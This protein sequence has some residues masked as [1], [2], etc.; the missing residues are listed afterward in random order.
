MIRLPLLAIGTLVL[1]IG[2]IPDP[3]WSLEEEP[4]A[5][6]AEQEPWM[7]LYEQL[8]DRLKDLE[9]RIELLE[10]LDRPLN[11]DEKTELQKENETLRPLV[12]ELRNRKGEVVDEVVRQARED[13]LPLYTRVVALLEQ[14]K[15]SAAPEEARNAPQIETTIQLASVLMARDYP[16]DAPRTPDSLGIGHLS[17]EELSS[18]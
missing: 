16:G 1:L 2:T 5:A 17:V 3:A 15:D 10:S 7:E 18:L 8:V 9:P 4:F 14:T 6:V 12:E 11:K 13:T